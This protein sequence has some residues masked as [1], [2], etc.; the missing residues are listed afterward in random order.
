MTQL[1]RT[2]RYAAAPSFVT[3]TCMKILVHVQKI[4]ENMQRS[5]LT[6]NAALKRGL[7]NQA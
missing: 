1:M 5:M 6:K 3:P 4:V 2:F 7:I